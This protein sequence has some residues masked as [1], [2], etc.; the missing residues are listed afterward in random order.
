[1]SRRNIHPRRPCWVF[2]GCDSPSSS[3]HPSDDNN[4]C[5]CIHIQS[6]SHRCQKESLV[7]SAYTVRARAKCNHNNNNKKRKKHT[8]ANLRIII[9]YYAVLYFYFYF[10][11]NFFDSSRWCNVTGGGDYQSKFFRPDHFSTWMRARWMA[12]SFPFF[13][14][15]NPHTIIQLNS[16]KM[17][18]DVVCAFPTMTSSWWKNSWRHYPTPNPPPPP[19]NKKKIILKMW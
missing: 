8:S 5:A 14:F 17:Q 12:F 18:Q 11:R 7:E 10:A 6:K 13:C 1:M 19:P 4:F 15:F 16:I 2:G 9:M 3:S